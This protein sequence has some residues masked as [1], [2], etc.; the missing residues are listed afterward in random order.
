MGCGLAGIRAG[1]G[2]AGEFWSA[3]SRVQVIGVRNVVIGLP[4]A[5]AALRYCAQFFRAHAFLSQYPMFFSGGTG[6][7]SILQ[8]SSGLSVAIE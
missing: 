2:G 4:L 6:A 1:V 5:C 7:N 3:E 8:C